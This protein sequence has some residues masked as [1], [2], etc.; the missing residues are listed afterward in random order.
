MYINNMEL[1][2]DPMHRPYISSN[3]YTISPPT[4]LVYIGTSPEYSEDSIWKPTSTKKA[5]YSPNNIIIFD[6]DNTL[7]AT[8]YVTR[9]GFIIMSACKHMMPSQEV[10]E[11]C[12]KISAFAE[13]LLEV[14]KSLGRVVIVTNATEGWVERTCS[15]LMPELFH[16]IVDI[17]II[18]ACKLYEHAYKHTDMWKLMTFRHEILKGFFEEDDVAPRTIMSIGDSEAERIAVKMLKFTSEYGVITTKSLK[19]KESPSPDMLMLQ[20]KKIALN[21]P[22]LLASPDH[23]DLFITCPS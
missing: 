20:L 7:L 21:L 11:K 1:Q 15:I 16:M 8:D 4:P 13:S 18:S 22:F 17:P 19:F 5:E 6:W 23:L 9:E 12:K 10:L 2:A 14:A 3:P